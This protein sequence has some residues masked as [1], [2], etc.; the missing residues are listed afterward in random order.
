MGLVITLVPLSVQANGKLAFT[1]DHYFFELNRGKNRGDYSKNPNYE[2]Y[3]SERLANSNIF[4]EKYRHVLRVELS[5]AGKANQG[6]DLSQARPA[7]TS[8][9]ETK[10]FILAILP[11]QAIILDSNYN[12]YKIYRNVESVKWVGN[13]KLFVSVETNHPSLYDRENFIIDVLND[14]VEK[15]SGK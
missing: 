7:K 12:I 6:M 4:K 2:Y 9:N 8:S 3:Q 13:T 1:V 11:E 5:A 15:V 14:S 10:E